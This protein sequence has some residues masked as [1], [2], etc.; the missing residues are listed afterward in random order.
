[1]PGQGCA[2]VQDGV[3]PG[4][5]PSWGLG[6]IWVIF[7]KMGRVWWGYVFENGE[8][9]GGVGWGGRKLGCRGSAPEV[10]LW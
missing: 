6:G 5:G 3:G 7:L 10:K 9:G 2:L 4:S 8:G 1:L